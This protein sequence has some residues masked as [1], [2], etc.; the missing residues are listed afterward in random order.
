MYLVKRVWMILIACRDAVHAIEPAYQ[1]DSTGLVESEDSPCLSWL[2][3]D[4]RSL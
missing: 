3:F 1:Y 2:N 4:I